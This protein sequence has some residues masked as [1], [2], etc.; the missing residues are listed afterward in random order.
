MTTVI[1]SQT[2]QIFYPDPA[3]IENCLS[4]IATELSDPTPLPVRVTMMSV[5]GGK[6]PLYAVVLR[7]RD[8]APMRQKLEQVLNRKLCLG[9]TS[10]SLK[11]EEASLVVNYGAPQK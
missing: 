8:K 7:S 9:T 5:H 11:A 3:E 1:P 4:R 10:F 2:T 6:P